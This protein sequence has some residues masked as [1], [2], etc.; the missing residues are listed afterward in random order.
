MVN[1]NLNEIVIC[2]N[3]SIHRNPLPILGASL[4]RVIDFEK[5]LIAPID[6]CW[7]QGLKDDLHPPI[8]NPIV[9]FTRQFAPIN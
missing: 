2:K 4:V 9:L 3:M 6:I 5:G 7:K 8:E 1:N